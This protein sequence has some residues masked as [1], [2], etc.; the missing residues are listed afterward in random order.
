MKQ[1]TLWE[2]GYAQERETRAAASAV[3]WDRL[4]PGDVVEWWDGHRHGRG[5]VVMRTAHRAEVDSDRVET[6]DG[7]VLQ[8]FDD[9]RT[10]P[11][12][13]YPVRLHTL[14]RTD[15]WAWVRHDT[16]WTF[17]PTAAELRAWL[18]DRLLAIQP[19]EAASLYHTAAALWPDACR[20]AVN[21]IW[22]AALIHR[23]TVREWADDPRLWRLRLP[24]PVQQAVAALAQRPRAERWPALLDLTW[25]GWRFGAA[26]SIYTGWYRYAV[27]VT[28]DPALLVRVVSTAGKFSRPPAP[29]P[30]AETA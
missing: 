17:H 10:F 16:A 24:R 21:A 12:C 22:T 7:R 18:R 28:D 26:Y 19:A 30:D 23:W 5:W 11:A 13:G 27:R 2:L 20:A 25:D 29:R 3:P 8:G 1:L 9:W 6:A 14:R 15:H 4:Q